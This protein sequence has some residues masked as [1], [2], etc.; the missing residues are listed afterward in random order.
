[1][2]A[3]TL[4]KILQNANL[5]LFCRTVGV[6]Q[7]EIIVNPVKMVIMATLL[8]GFHVTSVHVLIFFPPASE[9]LS[10]SMVKDGVEDL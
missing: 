10:L 8:S 5:S 9:Y 2:Y 6:L 3:Q 4:L 7:Q 1:M